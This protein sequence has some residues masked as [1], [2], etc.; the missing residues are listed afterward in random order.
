MSRRGAQLKND[1]RYLFEENEGELKF[2]YLNNDR[3]INSER[4]YL[5]YQH[6][7]QIT[8]TWTAVFQA[9]APSGDQVSTAQ[10][11]LLQRYNS[12][13]STNSRLTGLRREQGPAAKII[14]PTPLIAT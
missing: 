3:V 13:D 5:E 2:D 4:H 6:L 11:Q 8:T 12:G 7:S 10:R 14:S 9:H 1:F